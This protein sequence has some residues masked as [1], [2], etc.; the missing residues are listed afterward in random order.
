MFCELDVSRSRIFSVSGVRLMRTLLSL[1]YVPSRTSIVL[2]CDGMEIFCIQQV[3]VGLDCLLWISLVCLEG[4]EVL[5]VWYFL[6]LFLLI[7]ILSF[8]SDRCSS[9]SYRRTWFWYL[10]IL[11]LCNRLLYI[12]VCW[13]YLRDATILRYLIYLQTT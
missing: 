12:C 9:W 4:M 11:C 1:K 13:M 7:L 8:W 10:R 2:Q 3:V 5:R 6:F